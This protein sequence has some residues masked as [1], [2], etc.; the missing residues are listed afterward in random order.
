VE[1]NRILNGKEKIKIVAINTYNK[2]SKFKNK[3]INLKRMSAQ[4]LF[5]QKTILG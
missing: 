2:F 1:I 3:T 4:Y 5:S